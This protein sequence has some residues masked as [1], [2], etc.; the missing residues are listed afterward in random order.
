M[1]L[2]LNLKFT[3]RWDIIWFP[4][5]LIISKLSRTTRTILT[6]SFKTHVLRHVPNWE[7]ERGRGRGDKT[8]EKME[9]MRNKAWHKDEMMIITVSK[10]ER[11]SDEESVCESVA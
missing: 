11:V 10:I 4:G 9:P 3:D 5:Y 2:Y 1:V 7:Q 6:Q 8:K